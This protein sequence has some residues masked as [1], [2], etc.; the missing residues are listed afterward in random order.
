[1]LPHNF[2]LI[3]NL[4]S[5]LAS[6]RRKYLFLL[7]AIYICCNGFSFFD[8]DFFYIE[9]FFRFRDII[10]L[11]L[12]GFT[13]FSVKPEQVKILNSSFIK[14]SIILI[15]IFN[16][17]LAVYTYYRWDYTVNELISVA[18]EYPLYLIAFSTI[19]LIKDEK[20]LTRVL[21]ICQYFIVMYAILFIIQSIIGSRL[22]IFPFPYRFIE[23]RVLEIYTE[24]VFRLRA[25]G[26]FIPAY[27]I[28]L[29][30]S[31]YVFTKEKKNL[32]FLGLCFVA[33][34]LT[35][36]RTIVFASVVGLP[37]SV[38][39]VSVTKKHNFNAKMRLRKLALPILSLGIFLFFLNMFSENLANNVFTRYGSIT[40]QI[41]DRAGTYGDRLDKL[42]FALNDILP[43]NLLLGVG[44]YHINHYSDFLRENVYPDGHIGIFYILITNG[45][46]FWLIYFSFVFYVILRYVKHFAS[47]QNPL[48]KSILFMTFTSTL[49]KLI[50][51]HYMEFNDTIGITVFAFMIGLSELVIY[52]DKNSKSEQNENN[53]YS[54][55]R[56][57]WR[58]RT[59]CLQPN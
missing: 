39:I 41:I 6:L 7:F 59:S 23:E 34:A 51:W 32:I 20:I 18:R 40:S 25:W 5:L 57:S 9:G 13:I 54:L 31:L 26:K 22:E 45:L 47:V 52:F 2:W 56:Y 38:Y 19:I 8:R 14:K 10:F 33:T 24:K 27:F 36:D 16:F 55:P 30:F 15:V 28:P 4:L 50:A 49:T 58:R 42:E 29:F 3:L 35:F 53:S 1:M 44:L 21:K 37:L 46:I 48:Y 11:G 12:M 43:N 17:I